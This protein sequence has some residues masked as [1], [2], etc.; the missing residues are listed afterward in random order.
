MGIAWECVARLM[1][2]RAMRDARVAGQMLVYIQA[3]DVAKK[4]MLSKFDCRRA[5]QIVSMSSTGRL[6]GMCPLFVGM[7]VRLTAKLSAKYSIVHDA[8]GTVVA[9]VFDAREPI[10]SSPHGPLGQGHVKLVYM[11]QAVLVQFDGLKVD[12]GYGEGIVAVTPVKSAWVYKTHHMQHGQR[13]PKEMAMSRTQIPLAPERVRT[14]QTAQGLSMDSATMFL[15]R[16]GNMN[17]DDWWL[18]VYVMISRVRTSPQ[19]LVYG[20][21]PLSLFQRGPPSFLAEGMNRLERLAT[22][23]AILAR[24]A[25]E[26][27]GWSLRCESSQVSASSILP[28]VSEHKFDSDAGWAGMMHD[29]ALS[30]RLLDPGADPESGDFFCDDAFGPAWSVA[31]VPLVLPSPAEMPASI[32]PSA[33]SR[34]QSLALPVVLPPRALVPKHVPL[35]AE[36]SSL[37]LLPSERAPSDLVFFRRPALS[38][39]VSHYIQR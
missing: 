37:V 1:Q 25:R 38:F 13:M 31:A 11:P 22:Q 24:R 3:I 26:A 18:H 7:R 36:V 39:V 8:P 10:A 20:L 27:L 19:V 6:L 17:E 14:V 29:P 4:E 21:P 35:H 34:V 33:S 32:V 28:S 9:F 30:S 12:V 16:P 2:Y 23:H 15:Q 5:L